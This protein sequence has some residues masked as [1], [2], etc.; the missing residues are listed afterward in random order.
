LR[1]GLKASGLEEGRD[2]A[3]VVRDARGDLTAAQAAAGALER[4]GVDLIV[5]L[6]T[7]VTLAAKRATV[8]VPIV[9]AVGSDPVAMGLVD[10]IPRPGGRA[11]GVHS[12]VTDLTPKRLELLRELVP[13][14]RRILTF[15]NPENRAAA[16]SAKL[17]REAA[18]TLGIDFIE[19]H[20]TTTEQL[21][22]QVDALAATDA[23]AFFFVADAMVLSRDSIVVEKTNALRMPTMTTY[24]DAVTRGALAG[25]GTNYW[26]LGRRAADY[27]SRVL[28]GTAPRDLPVET[29]HRPALAF[30]L[31][32]AAAIGITVP[33]TLLARA[34]EVI[35]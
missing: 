23:D 19:R 20:V 17:A 28:T 14:V 27:V 4:D 3:L 15:Y 32:T 8:D 16:A 10:S 11:T 22:R 6:A 1:D 2:I 7:S 24:I 31:K 13:T 25:Y 34:D 9:F 33:P 21:A 26:D 5:T 35:E 30:N 29:I 18:R 12:I